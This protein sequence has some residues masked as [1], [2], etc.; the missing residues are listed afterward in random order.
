MWP[1]DNLPTSDRGPFVWIDIAADGFLYNMVR[2]ITGTLVQVGRRRMTADQLTGVLKDG[3]RD[4]AGETAPACGL[5]LMQV[6]YDDTTDLAKT[7]HS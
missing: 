6:E 5:Y 4:D 2:A 1:I 7:A 3:T